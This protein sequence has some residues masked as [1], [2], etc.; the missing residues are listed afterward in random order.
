MRPFEELQN[1]I[2]INKLERLSDKVQGFYGGACAQLKITSVENVEELRRSF[3][4][5]LKKH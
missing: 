2:K 3:E 5:I 4:P 1:E